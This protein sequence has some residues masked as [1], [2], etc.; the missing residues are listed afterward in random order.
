MFDLISIGDSVIDTF[1]PLKDAEVHEREGERLLMLRF[2]D[3]IPVDPSISMVGGNAANNSVGAARLNLKTALY[4]HVGNDLQAQKILETLKDE[5]VHLNYVVKDKEMSSNQHVVLDF[6]GERTILTCH[7]P[8]KYQ[9]PDIEQ[10]KW[11]YLTSLH[12]GFMETG[13]VSQL[14][15]YLERTGTKLY[16]NPGTFQI[17]VGIKKLPKILS[18]AEVLIMNLQESKL[19]LGHEEGE[20][21][22][23]KK[24]LQS[25]VDLGPRKAVITDGGEGSYG[26]DGEK[27]Y[28][29]EVFPAKLIEMTG[30]GDAYATGLLAGL[31][32]GE[33][34]PKAMRWGA[35]NGAAVVEEI[36]PQTG[37][38]S[39]HKMQEKLKEH[40]KTIAQT[41]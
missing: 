39:Y 36:G 9:L 15:N 37:L 21:I 23:V 34:L 7:Q 32:H 38:L 5:K 22:P 11:I 12:S 31:F 6:K 13:L 41:I 10:C 8:W 26:Y 35:A 16:F 25:L 29:I 19:V 28:H 3:K 18:L 27:F 20:K 1:V 33:D 4:T 17:K 14:T 2:G 30:A 24:L 40:S